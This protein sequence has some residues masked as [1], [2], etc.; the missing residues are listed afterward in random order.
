MWSVAKLHIIERQGRVQGTDQKLAA[1]MGTPYDHVAH[2]PDPKAMLEFGPQRTFAP[3]CPGDDRAYSLSG[4]EPSALPHGQ[5]ASASRAT[6]S[7]FSRVAPSRASVERPC[8]T[9]TV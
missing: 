4:A 3:D 2:L 9:P 8:T 6:P 5:Q 7:T 1:L